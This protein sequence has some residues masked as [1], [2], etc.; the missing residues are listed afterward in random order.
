MQHLHAHRRSL[1]YTYRHAHTRTQTDTFTQ[2]IHSAVSPLAR[3][4]VAVSSSH[5]LQPDNRGTTSSQPWPTHVLLSRHWLTAGSA[6]L[7]LNTP[8]MTQC[9]SHPTLQLLL[10]HTHCDSWRSTHTYV[11]NP[12]H[13]HS[14]EDKK[15][16]IHF[17]VFHCGYYNRGKSDEEKDQ[18]GLPEKTRKMEIKNE[19]NAD[20]VGGARQREI[21][22]RW[23]ETE[24]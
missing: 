2:D 3:G 13:S 11:D 16:R 1:T 24:C 14:K 10:W 17:S 21:S 7:L 12:L 18:V 19:G 9:S 23:Q 20:T 4:A 5:R 22:K 8:P 6:H 15:S